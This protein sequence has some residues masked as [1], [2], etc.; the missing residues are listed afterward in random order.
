MNRIS[1][2]ILLTSIF[3]TTCNKDAFIEGEGPGSND[4]EFLQVDTFKLTTKTIFDNPVS[5][6]NVATVLLGQTLDNRFGNSKA[7]F[8]TQFSLSNNSFDLGANPILDS[9]VLVLDQIDSYGEH[10]NTTELNV[11]ELTSE[12]QENSSYKNNTVL[13]VKPTTLATISNF[14]FNNTNGTIR[15]PLTTTFGNNLIA[16]FG[17]PAMESTDK[18]KEFFHGIFVTTNTINGDGMVSLNLLSDKS[19]MLLYFHSDTQSDTSYTYKI[20]SSEIRVNQYFHNVTSSAAEVSVNTEGKDVAYISS[21]TKFKTSLTFPDLT[22]L[23]NVIINKASLTVYQE[24]YGSS[25]SVS[26]PEPTKLFLFQ[27]LQDTTIEFLP[28]FSLSESELFGG[29]KALVE[30]NGQNT[31]AYTFYITKYVQSLVN[32]TAKTSD[33][34]ITNISNNTGS[35][36]KIGG[37]NNASLPIKLDVIYTKIK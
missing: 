4:L 9:V 22:S 10:N 20:S 25:E 1:I 16:Q 17:T 14:K 7:G 31:N 15:I 21:M 29:K 18:F 2:L 27:N 11:Y 34:Y 32:G 13:N 35:R 26:F 12:L 19:N 23:K 5:S 8:Y 33:L 37:G 30:I 6:R 28:D 3:L 36:I 24:D